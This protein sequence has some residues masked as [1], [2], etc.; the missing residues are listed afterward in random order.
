MRSKTFDTKMFE[1]QKMRIVFVCCSKYTLHSAYY[2]NT[3]IWKRQIDT[4]RHEAYLFIFFPNQPHERRHWSMPIMW[5]CQT[6]ARLISPPLDICMF[7]VE[8]AQRRAVSVVWTKYLKV[9]LRRAMKIF[10]WMLWYLAVVEDDGTDEPPSAASHLAPV[11]QVLQLTDLHRALKPAHRRAR[12][13][14]MCQEISAMQLQ[15]FWARLHPRA[16]TSPCALFPLYFYPSTYRQIKLGQ[17][18]KREHYFECKYL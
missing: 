16:G 9:E 12:F 15:L 1:K 8:Q 10:L 7:N 5:T 17:S 2:F 11:H 13:S 14:L 3:N 18:V 6:S 4:Y